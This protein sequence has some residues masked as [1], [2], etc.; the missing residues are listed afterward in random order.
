MRNPFIW[1]GIKH[2]TGS[3]LIE[4]IQLLDDSDAE[5]FMAAYSA[6]CDDESHAEHNLRYIMALVDRETAEALSELFMVDEPRGVVEPR[7]WW[8]NSSL[9]VKEGDE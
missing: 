7:Q 6:A 1:N 4:T 3:D 8:A 2:W 9:G 5:D